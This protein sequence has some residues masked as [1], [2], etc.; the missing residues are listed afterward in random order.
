M[1]NQRL[2]ILARVL[3]H[4]CHANSARQSGR[5]RPSPTPLISRFYSRVARTHRMTM[6]RVP[7]FEVLPDSTLLVELNDNSHNS[8][9]QQQRRV[10][11]T[12]A[13]HLANR[14]ARLVLLFFFRRWKHEAHAQRRCVRMCA[15]PFRIQSYGSKF[16]GSVIGQRRRRPCSLVRMSCERR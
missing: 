11:E 4:I 2:E 3:Q 15:A 12:C 1:V 14:S 8:A 7:S 16:Q 6:T 5:R 9:A 10:L 13:I